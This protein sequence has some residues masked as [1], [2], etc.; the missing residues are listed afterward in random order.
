MRWFVMIQER[1]ITTLHSMA[2]G[3]VLLDEPTRVRS[4]VAPSVEHVSGRWSS[5]ATAVRKGRVA[6]LREPKGRSC[7]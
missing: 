4:G 2:L 5:P 7:V 6:S 1:T 3:K